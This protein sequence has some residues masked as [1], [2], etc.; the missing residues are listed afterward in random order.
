MFYDNF[1][2]CSFKYTVVMSCTNEV[3]CYVP[4]LT[5]IT[6]RGTNSKTVEVQAEEE[7]NNS[8]HAH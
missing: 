8:M 3:L 5:E 6:A 7:R 2:D 1:F 4:L